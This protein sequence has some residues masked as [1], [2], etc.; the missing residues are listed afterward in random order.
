[1]VEEEVHQVVRLE[2]VVQ[3]AA[4]VEE[5]AEVVVEVLLEEGQS[6]VLPSVVITVVSMQQVR[7]I[8]V[9]ERNQTLISAMSCGR[10]L[11]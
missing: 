1:M 8:C 2:V 11:L 5:E 10:V 6:S 4:E 9:F 7:P 3:A